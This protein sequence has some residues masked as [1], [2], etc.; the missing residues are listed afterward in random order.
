MPKTRVVTWM[1]LELQEVGS[2]RKCH[3]DE[4]GEVDRDQVFEVHHRTLWV[5]VVVDIIVV[6]M[7][8]AA[9]ITMAPAVTTSME[10]T[11]LMEVGIIMGLREVVAMVDTQVIWIDIQEIDMHLDNQ[12]V[13]CIHRLRNFVV[14]QEAEVTVS[15]NHHHLFLQLEQLDLEHH[16][17]KICHPNIVDVHSDN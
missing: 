14:T 12:E 3:M 9:I 10:M 7:V 17:H 6:I 15:E 13:H 16:H 5:G 4:P 8:A 2:R 1:A 11:F